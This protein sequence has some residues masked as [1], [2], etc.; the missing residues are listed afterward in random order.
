MMPP[1]PSTEANLLVYPQPNDGERDLLWGTVIAVQA[2]YYRVQFE[3][4]FLPTSVPTPGQGDILLLCTRRTRLKKMGQQIMVGDRVRV[5]EAD[6][7]GGR[8]AIAQVLPRHSEL[9]R[10]PIANADQ[11]LLVFALAEPSLDPMQLSRFLVKAESTEIAVCLCLNKCDLISPT[12]RQQWSDRLQRWGYAPLLLSVQQTVGLT[13]VHLRLSGKTTV[14]SGPSGVGK[15]SLL[16]ALIPS[17]ELRVGAVSGKLL[18]GRHTTRHVELYKLPIGGLLADS[19]GFNQPD[20]DCTPT[21][22]IH[23]FPEARQ[24]LEKEDCHFSNCLHRDEPGC[25]VRGDWERYAHYRIFLEEA[26]A[27]QDSLE[28][29]PDAETMTKQKNRSDGQVAT[30]PKLE[31]KKYRRPS[32]RTEKQMLQDLYLEEE[33]GTDQGGN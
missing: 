12:E 6:W 28:R 33:D 11:I 10:P 32:R 9:N 17:V 29:S 25:A 16:N 5:E 2:N 14:V 1:P 31:S 23:C 19:P 30:E 27:R 26:I 13:A 3:P 24:R 8:G 15:S 4:S 20:L 21:T 22:L 18:R 7:I